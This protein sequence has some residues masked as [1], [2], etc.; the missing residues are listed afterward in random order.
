MA[1]LKSRELDTNKRIKVT[2]NGFELNKLLVEEIGTKMLDIEEKRKLHQRLCKQT[3][4]KIDELVKHCEDPNS[5]KP[6]RKDSSGLLD[7]GLI[8]EAQ[9]NRIPSKIMNFKTKFN[10]TQRIKKLECAVDEL[11]AGK[12]KGTNKL[13]FP[14][15]ASKHSERRS[16]LNQSPRYK[17]KFNLDDDITFKRRCLDQNTLLG[18]LKFKLD[19]YNT[20]HAG[21]VING[22][23]ITPKTFNMDLQETR[24][25]LRL[26]SPPAKMNQ[27]FSP[28]RKK[29]NDRM[30]AFEA[31]PVLDNY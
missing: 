2:N 19:I 24:K 17:S 4:R 25:R 1:E 5:T 30:V 9:H 21:S 12:F 8:Q 18:P 6:I 31:N 26:K 22:K 27:T 28:F 13:F 15:E 20:F 14:K 3:Q 23:P 7:L 10:E 16:S 11:M 29:E